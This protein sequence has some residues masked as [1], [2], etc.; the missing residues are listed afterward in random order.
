[1]T[2]T[3]DPAGA[4]ATLSSADVKK[5]RS[6]I[7][8]ETDGAALYRRLADAEANPD[9]AEV[10][11]KLA[12]TEDRH[13]HF[14]EQKLQAAGVSVPKYSPSFR[15]RV[16]GWVARRFGTNLVA[17]LASQMESKAYGMYDQQPEAV[18]AGLPRDERSH[19]RVFREIS[20]AGI[21]GV[22]IASVEG[23]HSGASGNAIRAAVLGANDGLVSNLSL[24][25]GVAGADPGGNIVLVT[26]VAGLLAGALS[27]ALGEWISVQ[28]SAEYF[29]RQIQIERDELAEMPEEEKEELVLIYRSRGLDQAT[30]QEMAERAFD[31]HHLALQTLAREELGLG[32]DE[33]GNPWTAAIVSFLTFSFGAIMPV[34][35]WLFVEGFVGIAGSLVLSGLGLV[36]VG[37]ATTFFTGRGAWFSAGRMLLF[38]LTA[39][40]ITFGIGSLLGV[41]VE[42]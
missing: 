1:M 13:R 21:T 5:L 39:A 8:D 9:L 7:K 30:A 6:Y 22:D 4:S 27:M 41:S 18:A 20:R 26:G 16:L 40:A 37:L 2:S 3:Q 12:A 28:N 29:Q 23:R 10:Y 17:P 24:V 15:T 11:R 34:I 14:W 35:P 36:L 42:G 25:M 33:G 19:A 31:N 32:G 38:G